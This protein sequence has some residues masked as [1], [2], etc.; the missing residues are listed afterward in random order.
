MKKSLATTLLALILILGFSPAQAETIRLPFN[1]LNLIG[2]FVLG[3]NRKPTDRTILVLHGTLAHL[4]MET[5]KNLQG[6]LKERG[7]NSLAINLSFGLNNRT[8]MYKCDVPHRHLYGDAIPELTHWLGWLKKKGIKDVTLFGHSRGGGQAALFGATSDHQLVKRLVLL[9]PA[10]WN[11]QRVAN[12]F[13]RSHK[14]PLADVLKEAH[15]L[16]KAGKGKDYMKGTG[17][18]YCPGADVTAES[19]LS[20][21]QPSTRYD[22]PTQLA[23]IKRPVLVVA[24]GQDKVVRDIAQRTKPIAAARDN[25][26]LVVVDDAGHFFLDLYAEDVV[27]AMEEFLGGGS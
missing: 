12:G 21:Y 27:D 15:A 17:I 6:V 9:A 20:Y 1:G 26:H 2:E 4:G 13:K 14:R 24:G 22:T 18:L 7:L 3:D 8:G 19:F 23:K 5:I 10:T 16:V 11:K 25:I